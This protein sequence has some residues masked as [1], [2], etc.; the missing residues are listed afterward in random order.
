ME[1]ELFVAEK[2]DCIMKITSA[3]T[4]CS[5]LC[6]LF[7]LVNLRFGDISK[8][9]RFGPKPNSRIFIDLQFGNVL[10]P[11]KWPSL[12]VLPNCELA[13]G[14]PARTSTSSVVV[15]PCCTKTPPIDYRHE[16][17]APKSYCCTLIQSDLAHS[18]SINRSQTAG[19]TFVYKYTTAVVVIRVG[20]HKETPKAN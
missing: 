14:T 7:Y 9:G 3:P 20:E 10:L 4:E 19:P 5:Q 17:G 15:G 12:H 8:L 18:R 1:A 11:I 13:N 16:F 2:S 6:Q